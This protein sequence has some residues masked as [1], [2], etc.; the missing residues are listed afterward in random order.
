MQ[1]IR[2]SV[3]LPVPEGTQPSAAPTIQL[4]E[5][6]LLPLVNLIRCVPSQPGKP[7]GIVIEV[8][9]EDE[10][11]VVAS[12]FPG[13]IPIQGPATDPATLVVIHCRSHTKQAYLKAALAKS[14]ELTHL[15]EIPAG[16]RANAE[17]LRKPSAMYLATF[18]NVAAAQALINRGSISVQADLL[19]CRAFKTDGRPEDRGTPSNQGRNHVW[20]SD[21]PVQIRD[22]DL[23]FFL[24]GHQEIVSWQ[25]RRPKDRRGR[26]SAQILVLSELARESL[27][28]KSIMID[29]V[30]FNFSIS[31]QCLLCKSE[32]HS[33]AAC[34]QR[35]PV[36]IPRPSIQPEAQRRRV[37]PPGSY[38]DAALPTLSAAPRDLEAI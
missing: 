17:T 30:T 25:I 8:S 24:Q 13:V 19:A 29:G 2:H 23:Y 26:C 9:T 31:S 4:I 12:K 7:P 21:L 33:E 38:A 3:L 27:L 10:L 28:S 18:A 11:R 32:D 16:I 22:H 35:R 37:S 5:D 6:V 14:G 1:L 15:K 36:A 34:P 20:L